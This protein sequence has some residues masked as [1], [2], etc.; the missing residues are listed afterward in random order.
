VTGLHRKK[1][2]R[3]LQGAREHPGAPR[4]QSET[5]VNRRA[6]PGKLR[7][8]GPARGSRWEESGRG[9]GL[10]A[11]GDPP[12][13]L[14]RFRRARSVRGRAL[15]RSS[16][17]SRPERGAGCGASGGLRAERKDRRRRR[18]AFPGSS[19]WSRSSGACGKGDGR[20]Q[21]GGSEPPPVSPLRRKGNPFRRDG[22]TRCGL[23]AAAAAPCAGGKSPRDT[24]GPDEARRRT[25]RRPGRRPEPGCGGCGSYSHLPSGPREPGGGPSFFVLESCSISL[26]IRRPQSLSSGTSFRASLK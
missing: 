9:C 7:R 6:G 13:S 14:P 8:R 25:G 3:D 19:E 2:R 11:A 23:S 16:G 24:D 12:V 20:T 22:R 21:A 26:P 18:A 4:R 5:R 15:R 10:R 17:S 1:A